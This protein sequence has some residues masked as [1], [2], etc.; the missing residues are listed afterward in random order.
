MYGI[1][2]WGTGRHGIAERL[3]PLRLSDLPEPWPDDLHH[4]GPW[5]KALLVREGPES[6][7]LVSGK[8]AAS[9]VIFVAGACSS[10][11]T[12]AWHFSDMDLLPEWGSAIC[13]SQWQGKGQLGRTWIS[14]PGN[15]YAALRL[16][17]A[18][19]N[20]SGMMSLVIGYSII[21]V[22]QELGIPAKLKWPNDV[23]VGEKKAG[24]ILIQNRLDISLAGVGLNLMS[25]PD[26]ESL[27]SG[28]AV[29]ATCLRV[30]GCKSSPLALWELLV[31]RGRFFMEE[32]LDADVPSAINRIQTNMIFRGQ[33]VR[34]DD[35]TG[36]PPYRATLMGLSQNGELVLQTD[37]RVNTIRSGSISPLSDS[38]KE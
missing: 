37:D 17:K 1:F 22:L 15:V 38:K 19:P 29:E 20:F 2:L 7:C 10:A 3:D 9:P 27:R 4:R 14:P 26:I 13:I 25:A 33:T 23:M 5:R 30:K 34:V 36:R 24:G 8:R 12:L 35:H 32:L 28:H 18:P 16:P 31:D 21:S 11:M 6:N